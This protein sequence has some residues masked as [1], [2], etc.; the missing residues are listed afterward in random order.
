MHLARTSVPSPQS[1]LLGSAAARLARHIKFWNR[2]GVSAMI[3]DGWLMRRFRRSLGR[4][5]RRRLFILRF[6]GGGFFAF[7]PLLFQHQ[8]FGLGIFV[9]VAF[10]IF[11]AGPAMARII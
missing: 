11:F 6:F 3:A 1:F 5:R 2:H 4:F 7:L 10:L 9:F 8:M